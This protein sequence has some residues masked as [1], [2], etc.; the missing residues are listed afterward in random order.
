MSPFLFKPYS[1]L[2]STSLLI[3]YPEVIPTATWVLATVGPSVTSPRAQPGL[4][5]SLQA[6]GQ[7]SILVHHVFAEMVPVLIHGC[8]LFLCLNVFFSE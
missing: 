4:V 5:L 1:H 8:L 7:T 6:Q 2:T 3:L